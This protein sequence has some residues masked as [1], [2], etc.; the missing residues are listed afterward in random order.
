MLGSILF[1]AGI[2]K[3]DL[4][5]E[6]LSVP[7]SDGPS[8]SL[9]SRLLFV[10]LEAHISP[11]R[12]G[13]MSVLYIPVS[14]AANVVPNACRYNASWRKKGI[15]ERILSVDMFRISLTGHFLERK[16]ISLKDLQSQSLTSGQGS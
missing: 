1:Q 10:Y 2:D 14:S 6:I 13:D 4:N 5:A 16:A 8:S 12:A 11:V 15:K 7:F 3:R 9:I